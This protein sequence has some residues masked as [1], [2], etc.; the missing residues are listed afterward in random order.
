MAIFEKRVDNIVL[1]LKRRS[2]ALQQ[3]INDD[4]AEESEQEGEKATPK[5][6]PK[7]TEPGTA[8]KKTEARDSEEEEEDEYGDEDE[9]DEEGF[10]G[11]AAAFKSVEIDEGLLREELFFLRGFVWTVLEGVHS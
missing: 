9:G 8:G 1:D 11:N 6:E 7:V 2:F 4:E 10:A 3:G 5:T